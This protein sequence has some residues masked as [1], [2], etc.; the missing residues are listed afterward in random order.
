MQK[1]AEAFSH[2]MTRQADLSQVAVQNRKQK[3]LR[4]RATEPNTGSEPK[5]SQLNRKSERELN[6]TNRDFAHSCK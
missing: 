3:L 6:P 2:G 1:H 4:L 5:G